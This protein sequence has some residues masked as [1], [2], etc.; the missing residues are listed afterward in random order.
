MD[1]RHSGKSDHETQPGA[2]LCGQSEGTYFLQCALAAETSVRQRWRAAI[3]RTIVASA[4]DLVVAEKVL[5]CWTHLTDGTTATTAATA[6]RLPRL[7][8]LP[9]TCLCFPFLNA[10][11]HSCWHTGML[12]CW[13]ACGLA[14]LRACMLA[15][16]HACM[17]SRWHTCI[18]ACW[19]AC[20]LAWGAVELGCWLGL[21][22]LC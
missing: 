7:P 22:G 4:S 21:L 6:P 5:A 12:A 1:L 19:H 17:L 15:C 3:K 10:C 20:V 18:L 16:W 8:R 14:C 9:R 11:M 13:N 2:A